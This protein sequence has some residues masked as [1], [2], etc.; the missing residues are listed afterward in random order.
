MCGGVT[1]SARD[2]RVSQVPQVL[3]AFRA[4]SHS[5]ILRLHPHLG[6]QIE[7]RVPLEGLHLHIIVVI[8]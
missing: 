6:D 5:A 1:H 4:R 3:P 7:L 8:C 2:L